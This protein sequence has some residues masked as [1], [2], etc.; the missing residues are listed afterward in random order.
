MMMDRAQLRGTVLGEC[1]SLGEKA[2]MIPTSRV[3]GASYFQIGEDNHFYQKAK[4]VTLVS[5]QEKTSKGK[6]EVRTQLD[7]YQST[8]QLGCLDTSYVTSVCFILNSAY[9][10]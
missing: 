2:A 6:E 5:V 9:N 8:A 10:V 1:P 4:Q 7:K 3:R